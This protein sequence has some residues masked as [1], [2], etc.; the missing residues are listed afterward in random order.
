MKKLFA[1]IMSVLMI[2]CFM[3]SMAFA[4]TGGGGDGEATPIEIGTAADLAK[5]GKDDGYP[6]VGNYIL[7][8][9]I[10]LSTYTS[11]TPIGTSDAPFKGT[12]DGKGHTITGLTI[13]VDSESKK[14]IGLVGLLDGG[15]V[16]NIK[17]AEVKISVGESVTC[18]DGPTDVGAA[19]G[20]I[21]NGGSVS[22]IH[23]LSGS[24]TGGKRVGGVVGSI[25]ANG[26][27]TGCSN[28]VNVEAKIYN[29][30]GIVGAAYYTE[31]GKEMTITGCQNSGAITSSSVGAGGIVGLSAANVSDC[32]NTGAVTGSGASIGGIVGEQKA[33]GSVEGNTNSGSVTNGVS[34][35][36]GNGGIIGWLRYENS[37]AY[38]SSE[39]ISVI[40]N[41]NS[42]SVSGGNDAGGIIGTVYHSA[43]VRNNHSSAASLSGTSFAARIIG[44]YQTTTESTVAGSDAAQNLLIFEG[45]TST[46]AAE[47]IN[48]SC[49][50]KESGI[51][52]NGNPINTQVA[53]V[54]ERYFNTIAGAIS[55][56]TTDDTVT[57]V[58]DLT[59]TSTVEITK[60]VAI[61]L[62]GKTITGENCRALHVKAGK[63]ELTGS[64]TVTSTGTLGIN[65]S[66]I[67]V[68][69]STDFTKTSGASA[70]LVVGENVVI[71]AP[72]SYGISAFGGDT[73]ETVTIYG[74][75]RATGY[76]ENDPTGGC[77]VSTYGTDSKTP[78]T[79]YIKDGAE[80]SAEKTNAIYLP[81]G[82]LKVEGGE[83]TGSTGIYFKSTNMEISGGTITG[84]GAKN[85]YKYCGNGGY[86]TGEAVTIDSCNYPGGVG[87][88]TITGGYFESKNA[89]A[90]GSYTS[91]NGKLQTGFIAGGTFSTDPSDY[92]K[93]N[94]ENYFVKRAGSEDSYTYT[95]LA[96]GDLTTGVYLTNPSSALTGRYYISDTNGGDGPWTVSYRSGSGSS[97]STTTTT[98]TD[99]VTNTTEDKT[100]GTG[101]TTDA[102]KVEKTIATVKTETKTEADGT[103]TTTATVDSTTATKIVE[104]AV[105][106]KSEE[107][108]VNTTTTTAQAVSETAAGTTTEVALPEQTV[109]A[110]ANETEAAVTIKSDAAEV[111]L[112][113]EA[114]K[115]LADQSGDLGTVSLV[116][117]TV[118]QSETKVEVDLKL[119]TSKGNVTE[120]K[121]GSVSVT[122]KLNTALAAKPVVCVYIDD[123]GTYHKV[124]GQKNAD[125]T[126]TFVTGHFSSYAVMAKDEAEKVIAEQTENVEKLVGDL[127]LTARSAKTA[128][129]SI[130]VTLAVDENAI[131][132]IEG[133]GYTV[134]YKFYR[135][136]KKSASYKAKY[137]KT[138]LTYTNT[139]GTRGTR[140]YYKARVMVYDAQG[141]L[142]AK[143]ALN[144]CRYACRIK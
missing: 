115:A 1:I 91:Q 42:G 81:A 27:I 128:K 64:G 29:V 105:E 118:A 138:G 48:A 129:G 34:D 36:Y 75:V 49:T 53:K 135:S 44:N 9:D 65:S 30:G 100:T 119:V 136:T 7:K 24:I 26:S 15:S 77:A 143:T 88:V 33:F 28:Q 144:Q 103:K 108:V 98:T 85:D 58:S 82:T 8:A 93:E 67:R 61:D 71:E 79:I 92:V 37:N 124:S 90:V 117:E 12:I 83:V 132:Q 80:I 21:I 2:A 121:G 70:E 19:V 99:N 62:S 31:V 84:T 60:D 127:V 101:S 142:I 35:A 50:D 133:L 54:G 20:R 39:I 14:Y 104:K 120:F 109:K 56:A 140:Y 76:D 116:V 23:V 125:G 47:N 94:G 32:Q 111:K 4:G 10:D 38:K 130:K 68:G 41:T 95:V 102:G 69:D 72:A 107:I 55:A 40:G 89:E 139:A 141:E 123:F 51:Y 110:I 131:K 74:T 3:P 17:F 97:S 63:L 25:V 22:D 112:D 86:S 46:T 5:I 6:L 73:T 11:W 66:V 16:K 114:V 57:M 13:T 52:T 18:S 137:E 45:N 96:K 122:V 134:K 113:T 106:N 87:E 126:Y 59:V 43:I 78:A